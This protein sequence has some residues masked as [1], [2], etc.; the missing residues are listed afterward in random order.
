MVSA[1]A[2]PAESGPRNFFDPLGLISS[3][4]DLE[5]ARRMEMMIGR[6]AMLGAI[7][8]PAAE[9]YHEQIAEVAGL[10]SKLAP[11]GKA[12]TLVNGGEFSPIVELV[13]FTSLAGLVAFALEAQAGGKGVAAKDL[14]ASGPLR[15]RLLPLSPLL[16]GILREAQAINGRIAMVAVVAMGMQEAMTGKAMIHATPF[17]FGAH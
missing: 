12:P 10:P 8:F 6:V 11:D 16:Y 17:F 2:R 13:V 7:G 9:L 15:S 4:G 3:P 14:A 1:T 5:S